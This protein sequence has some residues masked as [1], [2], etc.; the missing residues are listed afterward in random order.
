MMLSHCSLRR[1]VSFAA[2]VG[3]RDRRRGRRAAHLHG[4]L[5][6]TAG[7]HTFAAREILAVCS[8]DIVTGY[9]FLQFEDRARAWSLLEAHDPM[10]AMLS[11][12]CTM[13][14]TM[15]NANLAKMNPADRARRFEEANCL[16]DYSMMVGKRQCRKRR[17]FAHEHPQRARSWK[18][19]SVQAVAKE[20]GVH[21][22]SFDQCRVNLR[23]PVTKKLLTK[24]TTLLTNSAALVNLFTPLQ[25][26][27]SEAHAVIEGSEGGISLSKW[28][29]VYTPEFVDL[30]QKAV[31]AERES[32]R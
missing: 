28:C 15:Q 7:R 27:C 29:Q 31:K 23:T 30:L 16:L 5:L 3:H 8:F 21:K 11:S 6:A 10:F 9:D 12:P 2:P 17:L 4:I 24:R 22:V 26:C 19:P 25:C 13:F 32:R 1:Q 18:R 14:S 20:P